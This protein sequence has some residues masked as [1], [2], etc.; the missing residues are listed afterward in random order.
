MADTTREVE[1]KYVLP[2]RGAQD[3]PPVLPDLSG[4]AGVGAVRAEGT[5]EL[6]AVYHDTPDLRLAA[7]HVTLRRREG[8]HDEGWHLKF[9][10]AAGV[11]D[12]LHAPL[13]ERLPA[14]LARL[15]RSRTLGADVVPV[16]R[17]VTSRSITRL[18]GTD[19]TELVEMAVDAVRA[20]RLE[21][22]AGRAAAW[23]EVEA[24][25]APGADPAVL[26]AVERKLRKAGLRPAP[27]GSKLAR[28]LAETGPG[29]SPRPEPARPPR[30]KKGSAG[31]YLLAYLREQ[32]EAVAA[33]DPAVR[34]GLPD[35]VHQMRVAARRLRSALRS[36][37]SVLDRSVTDPVGEELRRLGAE[38]GAE[39]DNE[40]LA[41]H[42]RE[43][44]G[45]VPA[46]LLL[47]PVEARLRLWTTTSGT[48]SHDRSLA[49]LDGECHLALLRSLEALLADPPL[50]RAAAAAPR[51]TLSRAVLKE[52]ARLSGRIEHALALPPGEERDL[53]LHSARKAAKRV[54]YAAEA[55]V[56]GV[57]RPA[58][59]FARR[60]KK[61]QQLLGEHQDAVVARDTVRAIAVQAQ[62][63]GEAG[64]TWG[65]L[66]AGEEERARA[67][68]RELPRVWAKASKRAARAALTR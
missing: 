53:A 68:E 19:G 52:Y 63:A 7:A 9:P 27:T 10:V 39:R 12:E 55:A 16:V 45:A 49:T 21:G 43:R 28:A 20:E 32:A 48:R 65:L 24:E 51:A 3:G 26:D 50:R 1:R 23:S 22:P 59:R 37:R 41:A 35:S 44:V 5:V 31:E 30:A 2:V 57:G 17:L 14:E 40:V 15:V 61:V 62:A 18:L 58:K 36:Y 38:L 54:R 66:Y 42:L 6:D 29:P 33:L 8:G 4:A 47:G 13:S 60:I 64:F 11:R 46:A 34:R 25:L 56:P 67:C